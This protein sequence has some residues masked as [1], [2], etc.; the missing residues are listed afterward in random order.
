[1]LSNQTINVESVAMRFTEEF[2][3]AIHRISLGLVVAACEML[4]FLF[5]AWAAS[6]TKRPS[7]QDRHTG[8]ATAGAMTVQLSAVS[9]RGYATLP[10][11]PDTAAAPTLL[12]CCLQAA[13]VQY[14]LSA[15]GCGT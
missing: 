15:D 7:K 9:A 2:M 4:L 14:V 3:P 8:K 6:C 1:M 12:E 11:S 10:S 13:A 5:Q